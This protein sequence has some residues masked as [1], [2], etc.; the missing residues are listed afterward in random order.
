MRFTTI[1]KRIADK[2]YKSKVTDVFTYVRLAYVN[3]IS[4][5]LTLVN[6]FAILKGIVLPK[7]HI[8]GLLAYLL[9]S[10]A[11]VLLMALGIALGWIEVNAGTVRKITEKQAYW[12]KPV[13]SN[14]AAG[15]ARI[16]PLPDVVILW[17]LLERKGRLDER[18]R[19]CLKQTAKNTVDWVAMSYKGINKSTGLISED[20]LEFY[21]ELLEIKGVEPRKVIELLKLPEYR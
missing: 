9:V 13:W 2:F 16:Y 3:Y 10:I 7:L 20:C 18:A 4:F 19:R 14:V 5:V 12:R 6:T 17:K 11:L 8:K 15:S 1:L 21:E